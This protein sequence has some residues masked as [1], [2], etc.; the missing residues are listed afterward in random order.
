MFV[1]TLT[2]SSTHTLLQHLSYDGCLE[3]R[4]EI[5]DLF[6]VVRCETPGYEKGYGTKRLEAMM[7]TC[8]DDDKNDVTR[9]DGQVRCYSELYC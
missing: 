9:V 5:S 7:T 1:L 3:V 4:G 8:T 2:C 6:Y